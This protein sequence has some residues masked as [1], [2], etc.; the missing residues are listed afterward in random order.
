MN[1]VP[2]KNVVWLLPNCALACARYMS[3]MLNYQMGSSPLRF[4]VKY[5]IDFMFAVADLSKTQMYPSLVHVLFLSPPCFI[6][7]KSH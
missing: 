2:L 5:A 4:L 6:L 3:N 7:M 1:D